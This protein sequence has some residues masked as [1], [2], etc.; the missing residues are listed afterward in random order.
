[1]WRASCLCRKCRDEGMRL[2]RHYRPGFSLSP[3]PV[4]FNST[5]QG[6]EGPWPSAP[7]SPRTRDPLVL[8][9]QARPSLTSPIHRLAA[10]PHPG[11]DGV[12]LRPRPS[13]QR[14]PPKSAV[15]AP[16]AHTQPWRLDAPIR[17]F[18][19]SACSFRLVGGV[20][21]G[22]AGARLRQGRGKPAWRRLR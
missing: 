4:L 10:I 14:R 19:T 16:P 1:M 9:E 17:V 11:G 22:W 8:S 2:N 6:S 20:A 5:L 3:E 12:D 18:L 13:A 15:S 7:P 21:T